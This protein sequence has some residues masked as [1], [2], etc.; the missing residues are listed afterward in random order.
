MPVITEPITP[1]A[2]ATITV[3]VGVSRNRRRVLEKQHLPIPTPVP[4]RVEID[5]GSAL[6]GFVSAVF[7][8]LGIKPIDKREVY[9]PSTEEGKPF[10]TD[11]YDVS[12]TLVSG[13]NPVPIYSVLAIVANGFSNREG[14]VQ[15]LIG[16]DVLR[17][18]VFIYNG[19][20]EEFT[21]SF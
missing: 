3:L 11:Q 7:E 20:E 1:P 15:G 10:V 19:P 14:A 9:T 12:L 4:V 13:L 18:C 2:G 5:T 17:R 6:T 16:R 8:P 21:L